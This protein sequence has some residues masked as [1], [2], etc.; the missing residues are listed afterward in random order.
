MSEE[1]RNAQERRAFTRLPL[2]TSVEIHQGGAMWELQLHDISL[3]GLAVSEPDDWDADYSHPFNFKLDLASGKSLEFYAHLVHID[4][5][6]MGFEME[7]LEGEVLE[8]LCEL[9]TAELGPELVNEE[10]TLL[11]KLSADAG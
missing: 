4:P 1:F 6:R 3:T 7:H 11:A 10:K 9:M 8:T 5:G 2:T